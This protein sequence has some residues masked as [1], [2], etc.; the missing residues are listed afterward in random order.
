MTTEGLALGDNTDVAAWMRL[1]PKR[2]AA[3]GAA[4]VVIDHVVKNRDDQGR[5]AIGGQHK[6]AGVT[7]AAYR[8]TL[9]RPLARCHGSDPTT[10]VVVLT[11]VKDRVGYVR[12][13][14]ADGQKAGT[15]SLTAWPDGGVTAHLEP[16]GTAV[17]INMTV[18]AR[19]LEHLA[20]YDGASKNALEK[21]VEGKTDVIRQALQWMAVE[22]YIEVERKGQSYCHW[23]TD[24][25]RE[26]ADETEGRG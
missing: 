26:A 9:I 1:L 15:L 14:A 12:A 18:V 10:G 5:Y 25:G 3:A 20:I 4:V 7:G 13:R 8:F 22:G 16:P 24:K 11:V 19:I 21:G 17:E 6:L 23:L 2:F